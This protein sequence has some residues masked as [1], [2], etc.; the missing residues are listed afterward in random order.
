LLIIRNIYIS[1]MDE[2]KYPVLQNF[3]KLIDK[4]DMRDTT[5]STYKV[6]LQ[7]LV[8]YT[9]K[10]V[11]WIISN[12]K[13]TIAA[14]DKNG[15]TESQT[16]KGFV[17]SVMTL[18]K[19]T[20]GLQ[21]SKCKAYA[22][23]RECADEI[24]READLRYETL[25]ATERQLKAHVPW[26]E[27][28]NVRDKLDKDSVEYLLLC[29]YTMIPPARADF[30]KVRIYKKNEDPTNEREDASY[31]KIE[32]K[33]KMVLVHNE[34]KSSDYHK[35]VKELPLDLV[36]VIEKSLKSHPREYLIVSPRNNKPYE[37]AHSYAVYF[38]RKLT[39]I[40]GK[41]ASINMLRHSHNLQFDLNNLTPL[42]K[43]AIASDMMQSPST[44]EAYR[45]RIPKEDEK[46]AKK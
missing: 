7:K 8:E 19:H 31:L 34:F 33:G 4:L 30:N 36:Q 6:R 27:I 10:D 40:F 37:L 18:F 5:K 12:C 15:V 25:E 29:L 9:G 2:S 39:K 16:R 26:E 44:F 24:H 42:E 23:W 3:K 20:K 28:L 43:K 14:L 41:T 13:K 1:K 22:R 21:E 11:D 35:Y 46:K 38:D 45:F 32:G 17:N